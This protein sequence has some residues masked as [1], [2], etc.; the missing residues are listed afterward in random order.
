M[1]LYT[2][3]ASIQLISGNQGKHHSYEDNL[4]MALRLPRDER[5][6]LTVKLKT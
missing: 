3:K 1:S 4:K 2:D 6:M 5:E